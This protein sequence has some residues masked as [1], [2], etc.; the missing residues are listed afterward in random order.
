L[1]LKAKYT[2][3]TGEPVPAAA[4]AP[5]KEKKSATQQAAKP[6][7]AG[8]R[9]DAAKAAKKAAKEKEKADKA[10]KKAAN[11]ALKKA[12]QEDAA[13]RRAAA[14]GNDKH[15][16]GELPLNNSAIREYKVYTTVDDLNGGIAGQNVLVRARVE[17]VRLQGKK[18][19]FFKLRRRVHSVQALASVGK[20]IS[21]EMIAFCG[22]IN[23]E[24]VVDVC[25]TLVAAPEPTQTTQ[26]DIEL[27]IDSIF[28]VSKSLPKLPLQISDAARKEG[29]PGTVDQKTRLDNRILDLRTQAN[30]AI[31]KVQAG[32]CLYFREFLVSE[33]FTE[34]HSPKI[35]PAASEGGANVFKVGYFGGDAFLAQSP[36]L[37]K[38]MAI[39]SDF[40]RVFEIAPVFRAENSNTHRHLCEFVGLDMEMAFNE[41]YHE[42]LEVMD[43]M[44]VHIFKSLQKNFAHEIKVVAEQFDRAP[45]EFL[46]PSLRLEWPEAIAMLREAGET[47][48]DFED[49]S[50]PM[51]KRLGDLVKQKYHTDFYILDKYPASVR[52]FYTMLDHK[53]NLYSNSYDIMMRGEE[54]MSGA[55]RIHD[56]ELLVERVNHHQIPIDTVQHYIDSF[57][58]GSFPHGGGGVGMERVVMLFLGLP[59]IRKSSLFPR[60]PSRCTP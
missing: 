32:I 19:C 59:N 10:A 9:D 25:G 33:G 16:Y 31:F 29:D 35:I 21:E 44:F 13:A 52:P 22:N 5:K 30:Q 27:H 51:E 36:Q 46:E 28:V 40:D 49:I 47:I 12:E 3:V 38:Q 4:P 15:L 56:H 54:I 26:S 17:T 48:D 14:G 8:G 24:S 39:N 60:D 18:M 7:A 37:Y 42:V 45:F 1:A 6:A 58:Y 53:N 41:H 50:T 34:I 2:E 23:P 20:V 43:Q 57:K 55:Q 11:A